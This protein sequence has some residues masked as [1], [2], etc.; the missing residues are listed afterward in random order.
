MKIKEERVKNKDRCVLRG[1]CSVVLNE[2][3]ETQNTHYALQN[4]LSYHGLR[5]IH[6]MPE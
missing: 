1:T 6:R 3:Y 4:T 2:R 5:R